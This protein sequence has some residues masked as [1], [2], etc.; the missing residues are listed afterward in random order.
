MIS[1]LYSTVR[2]TELVRLLLHVSIAKL[3]CYC[4]H[5]VLC[6]AMLG[7][8]LRLGNISHKWARYF[9]SYANL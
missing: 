3:H 9:V 5:S 7:L 1:W 4:K 8:G 6:I 2:S